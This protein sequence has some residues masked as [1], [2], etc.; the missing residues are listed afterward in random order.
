MKLKTKLTLTIITLTILGT[1]I[2]PAY[3]YY[4]NTVLVFQEK[5]NY[6]EYLMN[7]AGAT[8]HLIILETL[9]V[10]TTIAIIVNLKKNK[11]KY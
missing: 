10:S 2:I 11:S 3:V 4:N 9:I 8:V 6:T 5:N 7:S 1:A